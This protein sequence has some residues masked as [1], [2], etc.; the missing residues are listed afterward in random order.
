M[1]N[2]LASPWLPLALLLLALSTTF[3]LGHDRGHFYRPGAHDWN[4]SRGLAIAENLSFKHNLLLFD[5]QTV[6][7]EGAP[8][9]MPYGRYPLG[10]FALIKLAILPFGQDL[11]AKIYAG[12][13]LMLLLFAAMAILAYHALSRLTS[14]R[15]IGLTATL[16]AFS[17]H[18]S[19]YYSDKISAGV[20][21]GV[22]GVMLTFHGMVFFVLEG[23]FRPLLIKTGAALLLG[24]HVFA[25][26]L[27]FIVFGLAHEIIRTWAIA[28]T[29]SLLGTL[30]CL[31]R[32][33][34]MRLGVFALLFGTVG[35]SFNLANEYLAL[36]KRP[37]RQIPSLK[38]LLERTGVDDKYDDV[39][40][41]QLAWMPF[42]REQF[43]RISV[44]SLP[45][46]LPGYV[47]NVL[48]KRQ[49]API[50][51]LQGVV[52]GIFAVSACLVGLAFSPHKS[53][54]APLAL[55][56]FCWALPLRRSVFLHSHEALFYIGIPLVLFSLVL[57][58]LRKLA[59]DD[60]LIACFAAAA[61]GVFVLSNFRISLVGHDAQAAQFQETMIDDFEVIREITSG[62]VVF[63]PLST[64]DEMVR[65]AGARFAVEYYLAGSVLLYN[66]HPGHAD[67][68]L[69]RERKE[70]P[71]LLTP[72]N[73]LMFL[74]DG[75][76][77]FTMASSPDT[78]SLPSRS[79]P[80]A[81]RTSSRHS[82]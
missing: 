49:S 23:H 19:L 70:G 38:S 74:Y 42:L 72:D 57:L 54:L 65:F 68:V 60:R 40:D 61:L 67:F 79:A 63:V 24:W 51:E 71:T 11:S 46:S 14:N 39:Y 53:L 69:S 64:A 35:V 15:W 62:K 81:G 76:F 73:R 41:D 80:P 1:K 17:S 45:S 22:V 2:V 27:L 4:S 48:G 30:K 7:A 21:I 34:Y 82:Q 18:Y 44:M 37:L 77:T 8:F 13:I 3:L 6:D 28:S 66:E 78:T 29:R 36:D 50:E 32:S 31:I 10:G 52:I 25:L 59:K 47:V 33:R 12:R 58:Y 56:N 43:R 5:F 20:T 55:F 26:L 9:Y 16:L 75:P